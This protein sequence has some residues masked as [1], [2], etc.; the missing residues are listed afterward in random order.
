MGDQL[1]SHNTITQEPSYN[2]GAMM[3]LLLITLLGLIAIITAAP[4]DNS[5]NGQLKT[6]DTEINLTREDREAKNKREVYGKKKKSGRGRSE[7]QMNRKA[8]KLN[9][10]ERKSFKNSNRNQK[11]KSKKSNDDK[12]SKDKSSKIDKN[13][14]KRG[15]KKVKKSKQNKQV[16]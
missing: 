13:N 3:K 12:K 14:S 11:R 6:L 16:N 8:K 2:R 5:H 4:N 1:R 10:N 9:K 15:N 7:V